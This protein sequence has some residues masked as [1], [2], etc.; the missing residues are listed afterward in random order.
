MRGDARSISDT[1]DGTAR[2][3]T[4]LIAT[5]VVHLHPSIINALTRLG[6]EG[7]LLYIHWKFVKQGLNKMFKQVDP[8][9]ACVC[10]HVGNTVMVWIIDSPSLIS[11]IF[12]FLTDVS[13][14]ANPSGS[15]LIISPLM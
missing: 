11:N 3:L 7:W 9:N 12:V 2:R 13:L 8:V 5:A 15:C 14:D 10:Q 1:N 6:R 4:L